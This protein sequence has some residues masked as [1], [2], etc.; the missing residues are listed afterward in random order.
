VTS[1]INAAGT[2]VGSTGQYQINVSDDKMVWTR[3]TDRG[4]QLQFDTIGTKPI[5]P[6]SLA[7]DATDFQVRS[8]RK[9]ENDLLFQ[10]FDSSFA[11][12]KYSKS[13]QLLNFHSRR[14]Y[15]NDPDYTFSFV[16]QNILNTLQTEAF[17]TYNRNEGYTQFGIS[18]TYG[19]WFPY[20]NV[21]TDY[22]IDRNVRLVSKPNTVYW[23]EWESRV[24]FLFPFNLTKGRSFTSLSLGTDFVYNKRYFKGYYKDTFENRGFGYLNNTIEFTNQI[25]QAKKQIYPRLAQ[26][27]IVNYKGEVTG[28]EARQFLASGSFYLPGFFITHNVV[29]QAAFQ[30]RDSLRN[31]IYSNSFPFSRGYEVTSFYRMWKVGANYHLPL[32]YPDWGFGNIVYFLRVRANLFF[33]FTRVKDFNDTRILIDRDFR[34]FGTEIYFD[35]KWWNQLPLSIGIRYSHLLDPD[36][37]GRSPNQWEIVLPT[38]LLSRY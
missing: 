26:T 15:I 18:G 9:P 28:I 30:G 27:L 24:G 20:L 7:Q 19:Q 34:S 35:T 25:Q 17:V 16:S 29:L 14:P 13:F 4:F 31:I 10:P 23:D 37:A 12:N 33:D 21:G 11:V 3:F 6:G 5:S 22:T 1:I 36:I 8:L 32:V 2:N 38:N